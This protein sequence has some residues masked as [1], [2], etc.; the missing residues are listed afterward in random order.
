[1]QIYHASNLDIIK[2]LP[3]K[4][5]DTIITDPPYGMTDLTWDKF[6]TE[7]LELCLRV[8]KDN[9]YL[10]SFGGFH[11]QYAIAQHYKF[12]FS[13]MWLKPLAV[14]RTHTAKKPRSQCEPYTVFAHPNHQ[15][16]DLTWNKIL[17]EGEPY[18]KIQRN[19][20]YVRDGKNQIDRANTSAWTQDG[21]VGENEGT[22]QQTDVL[23]GPTKP[24]MKHQE[25]TL[26]PTQKPLSIIE[27][28]VKWLTNPSDIILDPFMGSGTTGVAAIGL[29]RD[30]IGIEIDETYFSIAQNRLGQTPDVSTPNRRSG[31]TI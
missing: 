15:I 9:G 31:D 18:R 2:S 14:M 19:T 16:K 8:L 25:R 17:V 23:H 30:F 3:D 11:V 13:G 5:I 26:H 27:C 1:M 6:P 28:L 4:S 20:G 24:T 7:W 22:R 10:V 21:Y 12:R 29:N